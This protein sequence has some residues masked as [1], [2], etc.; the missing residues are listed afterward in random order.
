MKV[1]FEL[2]EAVKY[3]AEWAAVEEG[4][5]S[6]AAYMKVVATGLARRRTGR[7]K[8]VGTLA[9]ALRPHRKPPKVVEPSSQRGDLPDPSQFKHWPIYATPHIAETDPEMYRFLI[10]AGAIH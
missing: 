3:H 7:S 4:Y 10:E 1:Q 2:S 8:S 9:T 5:A 6:L